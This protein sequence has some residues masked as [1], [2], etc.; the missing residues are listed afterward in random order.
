MAKKSALP[1]IMERFMPE[2]KA[3]LRRAG[4]RTGYEYRVKTDDPS[5]ATSVLGCTRCSG[6]DD[7]TQDS[8]GWV[9]S[10]RPREIA[11]E[12]AGNHG[13]TATLQR[14]KVIVTR[15]PGKK[16]VFQGTWVRGVEPI[17]G[18]DWQDWKTLWPGGETRGT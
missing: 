4:R 3:A 15:E 8:I 5:F 6:H 14:R 16:T 18:E 2:H 9:T 12:W 10:K 13:I 7:P 17:L 1:L 11:R